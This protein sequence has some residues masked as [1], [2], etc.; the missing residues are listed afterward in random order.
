MESFLEL[1]LD[2]AGDGV[3][4]AGLHVERSPTLSQGA[5]DSGIAADLRKWD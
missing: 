5:D 2:I 3:V 1:A 4:V